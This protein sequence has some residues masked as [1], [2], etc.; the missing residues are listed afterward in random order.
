VLRHEAF[1]WLWIAGFLSRAGDAIAQIAMPLL[2]YDL[3]DSSR[4]VGAILVIQTAPKVILAPVA[5]L[6]A[7]RLDRRQMMMRCAWLRAGAV[8]LIPFTSEIWQ[9]A[10]LAVIVSIGLVLSLPAEL[11]AM[12]LTVPAEHLVPA[13]SLTQV[14]GNIMKIVG[15][16]AGAALIAALGTDAAFWTEAV[17]F[18]LC[19]LCLRPVLIPH[20]ARVQAKAGSVIQNAREEI[21]DG[22]RVVWRTPI[23]RGVTATE[24]LWALIGASTS[25]AGLVYVERTLD[26]GDRSE[27]VYGLLSASLA[28]GALAGALSASAI[29]RRVGRPTM[30]ALGYLG[31]LMVIPVLFTPP[32]FTLYGCW[33]LFGVADALAVIAMQAYLAES[34]SA[35]MR[36]RVYATWNGLITL[37]WMICYATIGSVTDLLGPSWTI[38]LAGLIVGLGG[39]LLLV[40]TSALAAVRATAVPSGALE[41]A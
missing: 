34:V 10:L 35:E 39:P 38:A 29:E 15:P 12:P 21:L 18:V 11:S 5:G 17:C 40:L 20:V 30:L 13:L 24:C 41:T 2:V 26:L 27:L 36:G 37:A 6:L 32:V 19:A 23:V 22:M 28:T 7:D 25:I 33:F 31:P 14:T 8:T 16:A 3:T 4:V 1:R 9:L